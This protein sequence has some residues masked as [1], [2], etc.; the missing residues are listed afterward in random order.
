MGTTLHPLKDTFPIPRKTKRSLK[1]QMTRWLR[2]L[3][4]T[5]PEETPRTHRHKGWYW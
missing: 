3:A 4:K 1:K 5:H 2:R